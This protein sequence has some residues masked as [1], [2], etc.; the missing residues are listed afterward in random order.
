MQYLTASFSEMLSV[1]ADSGDDLLT[2]HTD[3]FTVNAVLP[4][5]KQ[6][7]ISGAQRLVLTGNHMGQPYQ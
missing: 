4:T 6:G 5:P 1:T 2:R 3:W 7:R